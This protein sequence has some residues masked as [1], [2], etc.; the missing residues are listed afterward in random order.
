MKKKYL[1][2]LIKKAVRKLVEN[3]H[4]EDVGEEELSDEAK[5]RIKKKITDVKKQ[6]TKS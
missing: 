4:P 1:E 6:T 3:I 5:E 2:Q